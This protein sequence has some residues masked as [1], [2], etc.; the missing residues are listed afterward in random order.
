MMVVFSVSILA[1]P[2]AVNETT[3]L[4]SAVSECD[5]LGAVYRALAER[6]VAVYKRGQ[7]ADAAGLSGVSILDFGAGHDLQRKFAARRESPLRKRLRQPSRLQ[8]VSE[9]RNL[10]GQDPSGAGNTRLPKQAVDQQE[11]ASADGRGSG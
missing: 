7:A 3:F 6:A 10:A 2:G 5:A 9:K 11:R 4:G 1:L 8:G